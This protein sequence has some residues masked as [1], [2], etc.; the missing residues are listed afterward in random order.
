[1]RQY[2]GALRGYSVKSRSCFESPSGL[3][4]PPPNPAVDQ[5]EVVEHDEGQ[6]LGRG[7]QCQR[8]SRIS[9]TPGERQR[10]QHRDH[11]GE[12]LQC[13]AAHVRVA[14]AVRVSSANW[15]VTRPAT[16]RGGPCLVCRSSG[17]SGAGRVEKLAYT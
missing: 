5:H 11:E 13:S 16:P 14:L 10:D 15:G 4:Q 6:D 8:R 7:R 3:G 12:E 9:S 1:M 2:G 17:R